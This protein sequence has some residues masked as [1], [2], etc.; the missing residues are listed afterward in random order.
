MLVPLLAVVTVHSDK[1]DLFL[2]QTHY[3]QEG[4]CIAHALPAQVRDAQ[5]GTTSGSHDRVGPH[6]WFSA[7]VVLRGCVGGM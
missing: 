6:Q 2:L 3:R 7:V 5:S 4:E 1:A